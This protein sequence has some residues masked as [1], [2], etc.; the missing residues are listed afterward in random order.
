[1]TMV[2]GTFSTH[3][4]TAKDAIAQVREHLVSIGVTHYKFT[5]I[6]VN[7]SDYEIDLPEFTI[8]WLAGSSEYLFLP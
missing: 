5:S 4:A 1:M 6:R 3:A 8:D 2:H 7:D